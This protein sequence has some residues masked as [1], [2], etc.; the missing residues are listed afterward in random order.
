MYALDTVITEPDIVD[1][2]FVSSVPSVRITDNSSPV[3]GVVGKSF[4]L[5]T[6]ICVVVAADILPDLLNPLRTG[7]CTVIMLPGLIY[8]PASAVVVNATVS[9]SL[10]C[11]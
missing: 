10:F 4:I 7:S 5:S 11:V 2:V 3:D 1:I 8:V 9:V 6:V